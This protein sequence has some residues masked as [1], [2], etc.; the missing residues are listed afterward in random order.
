MVILISSLTSLGCTESTEH[1]QSIGKQGCLITE[2]SKQ[3]W[4]DVISIFLS[5]LHIPDSTIGYHTPDYTGERLLFERLQV[6][7][8]DLRNFLRDE[9]DF[10]FD[11]N[12]YWKM[13]P[14]CSLSFASQ[15]PEKNGNYVIPARLIYSGDKQFITTYIAM[16]NVEKKE[17]GGLH[18]VL[19]WHKAVDGNYS[20]QLLYDRTD[21]PE[22]FPPLY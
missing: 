17:Y 3:D 16:Y 9:Y 21:N 18:M 13:A 11:F 15:K 7:D 10:D 22:I 20:W 2:E 19:G 8:S 12:N 14:F 1:V 4:I 6:C 5:S